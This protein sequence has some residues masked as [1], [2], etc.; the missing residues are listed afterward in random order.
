MEAK[1]TRYGLL[2]KY[3]EI[4]LAVA[5]AIVL[6]LGVLGLNFWISF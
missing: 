3:R 4:V 1:R 6:D 2:G 5:L